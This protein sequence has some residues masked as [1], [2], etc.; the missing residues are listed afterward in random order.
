MTEKPLNISKI[1]VQLLYNSN[2]HCKS[3]Y[4]GYMVMSVLLMDK[5]I[6]VIFTSQDMLP[7]LEF[8]FT[9]LVTEY[10]STLLSP[11]IHIT[12]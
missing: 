10:I 2:L 5:K 8:G 4:F 9:R 1:H 7:I 12:S 11:M 3:L 6:L